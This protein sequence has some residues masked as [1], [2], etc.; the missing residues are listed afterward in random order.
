MELDGRTVSGGYRFGYQS[1][2][3]DN[4]FKGD[5]NSYTTEFRQCDPSLGRWL[6]RDALE[7]KYSFLS[8]YN[9]VSNNPTNNIEIDGN[10]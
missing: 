10:D 9:F 3:K 4:E 2:E 5:G 8:P 7:S 6:I 1:S